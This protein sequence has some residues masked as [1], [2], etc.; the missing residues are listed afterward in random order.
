MKPQRPWAWSQLPDD[1]LYG[2]SRLRSESLQE[3]TIDNPFVHEIVQATLAELEQVDRKL[4]IHR[5][6]HLDTPEHISEEISCPIEDVQSQLYRCRHSF[7]RVFFQII[8][9]ANSGFSESNATGE[10]DTLDVNLEKLLSSTIS[11]QKLDGTKLDTLRKNVFEA[12]QETEYMHPKHSPQKHFHPVM[13]AAGILV[14]FAGLYIMTRES[15]TAPP[16]ETTEE[17]ST[18]PETKTTTK[19]EPETQKKEQGDL[20]QEELKMILTLGQNGN[21]DALLEILKSGQLA[22]QVVAALFIGK[23]ADPSAIPLL[24]QAEEQWYPESTEDNPFAKAL[25]EILARFPEAVPDTDLVD[26]EHNKTQPD[27]PPAP[28]PHITGIVSDFSNQPVSSVLLELKENTLFSKNMDGAKVASVRTDPKG[29]Y[30]FITDYEGPAYLTA[31]IDVRS[32]TTRTF[33]LKKDAVCIANFGGKPVLTGSVSI[34]SNP[35]SN[36]TVYLSDTLDIAYASFSQEISSNP[37]GRVSFSGVFPGL[38]FLLNKGLDNRVRRL[39]TIEVP[40][41]EMYYTDLN[42][43]TVSV[44]SVYP[45]EP[46][47]PAPTEAILVYQMDASDNLNQVQ[48]II[49]K[50]GFILFDNVIPGSYVLKIRLDSGAW[51]QQNVNV[52][53]APK[54]QSVQL[55][56]VPTETAVLAG[57]FLGASP[58]NLFLTNVNQQI[59]I[60]IAPNADG[61]YELVNIPADIYSLACFVKG[62]LFEFTQIDLQNESEMVMDIDPAEILKSFSPLYVAVVDKTGLI[63]TRYEIWLNSETDIVS[64]LST[65][66][67]AFLAA[68]SGN[69][70]LSI[71]HQGHPTRNLE[72]NLKPSS[73]LAEPD[74]DNT[75]LI[76]LGQNTP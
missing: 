76:R 12:I 39:A 1:I 15:N 22:N 59:H 61:S 32:S 41:T 18:V 35:L 57:R 30:A 71:A 53:E 43:E 17:T 51:I 9:N 74:A 36:Q 52:T 3:K 38:Y 75:I 23:L 31:K 62:K 44:S 66:R 27:N 65:G 8:S 11:Y 67:G 20:D 70:T 56:P 13:I 4:L 34:D 37:D 2:L 45:V 21:V 24:E 48:A 10:I 5:Y 14:L 49:E 19:S 73:L 50:D 55:S 6:N 46:N 60:D 68:P 29:Q 40:E 69:Y 28:I 25:A 26:S 42:L 72:I 33:W 7:R 58:V 16:A 64:T 54:E 63:L 47:L